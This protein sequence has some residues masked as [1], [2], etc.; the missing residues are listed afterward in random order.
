M[1]VNTNSLRYL[2]R[3]SS[4]NCDLQ[5]VNYDRLTDRIKEKYSI[6]TVCCVKIN[7]HS[8]TVM[9]KYYDD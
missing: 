5:F 7:V 1:I 8:P 4:K 6:D 9:I 2:Q 3:R